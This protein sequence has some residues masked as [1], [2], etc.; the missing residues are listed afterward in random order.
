ADIPIEEREEGEVTA[1]FGTRVAPEETA[2]LNLAFDVTPAELVTA[3]ITE[4]GVL[5]PPY[6]N[7]IAQAFRR[8]SG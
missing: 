3:I 1:V 6:E 7:S 2:A 5:S 8:R 4:V